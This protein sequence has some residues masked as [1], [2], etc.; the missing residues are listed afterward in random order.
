MVSFVEVLA[1]FWLTLIFALFVILVVTVT[2]IRVGNP[3]APHL[4]CDSLEGS[5][6]SE[7]VVL[8]A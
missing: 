5:Q 6:D 3:T 7:A 4:F 1:N 2:G 8:G